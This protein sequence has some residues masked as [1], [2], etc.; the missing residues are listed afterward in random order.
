VNTPE[1][2]PDWFSRAM[3][4]RPSEGW[5][6]VR[7]ARIHYLAWGAVDQPGLVLVHGGGAHAHWWSHIAPM[8]MQGF[9]ILA[10]DLSGHGDSDRREAYPLEVWADEI[11][12]V[13]RHG[14]IAG[15]PVVVGHSMGG[16]VTIATAAFRPHDLEAIVILDSPVTR[17]DPE[18]EAARVGNAFRPPRPYADRAEALARFRTVP[19][20]DHYLPYVLQNV[21]E[22]SLVES[23]E[24]W[25][26]KFDAAVFQ[27][28]RNEVA[29]LLGEVRCRVALFSAE[30]GLMTASVGDYMYER[31]GRTAPLVMIPEA[32]HHMMLDQPLLLVTALRTLLADWEHSVPRRT[33]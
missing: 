26:W 13:A 23:A 3:D 31:L 30:H 28:R 18:V 5:V 14:G 16:F 20:Q 29:Q 33:R 1:P 25:T 21:A 32:G 7:G 11:V 2:I 22:H 8:L 19:A 15:K 10:L 27:A 4:V 12:A 17:E 9:R 24:G 6:D